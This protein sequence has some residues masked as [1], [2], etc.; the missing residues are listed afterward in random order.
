[1]TDTSGRAAGLMD[2]TAEVVAA[3]V[4]NNSLPVGELR[5]LIAQAHAALVGLSGTGSTTGPALSA[6]PA[7][8]AVPIKK[9]VTEDHLL[10][11]EDGHRFKS[12]KRHLMSD[13][14][15]SPESY[16]AKWHLPQDYPMVAPGY[17]KAR[18]ELA[19]KMGL[20]QQRRKPTK[21]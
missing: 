10:C 21:K 17:A 9:S 14:G 2:L 11:L 1:M 7:T 5:G 12:L 6:P 15:L 18:S 4:G 20:G 3:F 19:K 13:H 16:R 8:P